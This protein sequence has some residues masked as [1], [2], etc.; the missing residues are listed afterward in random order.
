MHQ[1]TK[2]Q[3]RKTGK[4]DNTWA[5]PIGILS[6]TY[7]Y[8]SLYILYLTNGFTV[9]TYISNLK[10]G[11][12]KKCK[13]PLWSIKKIF[14]FELISYVVSAVLLYTFILSQT[15]LPCCFEIALY[16]QSLQ[17][18]NN[19]LNTFCK[20]FVHQQ[21]G[22]IHFECQH[23]SP[24][25]CRWESPWLLLLHTVIQTHQKRPKLR[26]KSMYSIY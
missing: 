26:Y 15:P 9:Y 20:V 8:S 16:S 2:V 21:L 24:L 4:T 17:G 7:I 13:S 22:N 3:V 6:T 11:W 5:K 10:G 18:S 19:G 23:I 25:R 12:F 1:K 14:I